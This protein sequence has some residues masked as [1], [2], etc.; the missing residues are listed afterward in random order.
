MVK[1]S[2]KSLKPGKRRQKIISILKSSK[3]PYTGSDLAERFQVTRQVIVQDIALIRAEGVD[4]LSTSRGYLLQKNES[5]FLKA[6]IACIHR[7][8]LVKDELMIMIEHGVRILDVRVEHPIY[9]ELKGNLMLTNKK[10]VQEFLEKV[11]KN[12]AGLLAE[13]TDG[14]HLHTIEVANNEVLKNL[15]TAL[16]AEGYL[17]EG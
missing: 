5:P 15:K 6:T 11:E 7:D 17:L 1:L 16:S 14:I 2:N 8:D 9:G 13:L 3:E 10:E 4:I 12:D